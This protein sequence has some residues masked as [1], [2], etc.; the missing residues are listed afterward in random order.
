LGSQ[1]HYSIQYCGLS[2]VEKLSSVTAMKWSLW[3]FP[4]PVQVP[5]STIASLKAIK[6]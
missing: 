1:Y 4:S 6:S 2:Y 3:Y 5:F